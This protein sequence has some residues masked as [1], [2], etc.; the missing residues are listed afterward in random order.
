MN[1][2]AFLRGSQYSLELGRLTESAIDTFRTSRI[3][4]IVN[5]AKNLPKNS[6]GPSRSL[7]PIRHRSLS[8]QT[9][10]DASNIGSI[11]PGL[12]RIGI[13]ITFLISSRSALGPNACFSISICSSLSEL[14][15]VTIF[16][17]ISLAEE[18]KSKRYE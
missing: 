14:A 8:Y 4:E 10:F 18:A 9:V 3:I 5:I 11:D 2:D 7:R 13:M 12:F 17:T 1:A 6:G 15:T 16:L